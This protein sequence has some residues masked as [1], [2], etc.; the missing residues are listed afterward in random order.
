MMQLLPRSHIVLHD[1]TVSAVCEYWELS[2]LH[3]HSFFRF[4]HSF[5]MSNN[6]VIV[7]DLDSRIDYTGL[8]SIAGSSGEY[9]NSL[10]SSTVSGATMSFTFSGI[11]QLISIQDDLRAHKFYLSSRDPFDGRRE[12][13]CWGDMR[14]DFFHRWPGVRF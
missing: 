10:H 2:L 14:G 4:F 13:G 7:D 11:H 3:V 5:F 9:S 6:T 12:L 1:Q 8:W